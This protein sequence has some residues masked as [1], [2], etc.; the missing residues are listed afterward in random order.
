SSRWRL[1]ASSVGGGSPS[2]AAGGDL[3]GTYPNPTV[4][5]ASGAFALTGVISPSQI[6]ADQN[7]YN[8]TGLSTAAV[9]RLSTDA[10]R[11]LTGL[12]GGSVGRSIM[13]ANIGGNNV[14]LK[15]ESSSSSAANRFAVNGDIT[16][17]GDEGLLLVYD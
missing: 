11:N 16:L 5:Q 10:C 2:G 15:D 12:Q 14:I 13:L 6:T 3:A 7:D 9:L 8:P 17:A 4:Q 1:V